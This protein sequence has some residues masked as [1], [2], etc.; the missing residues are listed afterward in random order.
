MN[1]NKQQAAELSYADA[2]DVLTALKKTASTDAS[3][4]LERILEGHGSPFDAEFVAGKLL[5]G[6]KVIPICEV[7]IAGMKK[8]AKK[9]AKKKTK[10]VAK[11]KTKAR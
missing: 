9:A 7:V 8:P 2:R 4:A 5:L 1:R 3:A 10:K 6:A 11:K